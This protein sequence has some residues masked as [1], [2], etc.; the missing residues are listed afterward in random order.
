[1]TAVF[2]ASIMDGQNGNLWIAVI[3]ALAFELPLAFPMD[4]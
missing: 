4:C 1:M 2:T 3:V